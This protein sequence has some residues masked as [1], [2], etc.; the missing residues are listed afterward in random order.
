L[1]NDNVNEADDEPDIDVQEPR[2]PGSKKKRKAE[3]SDEEEKPAI[4]KKPRRAPKLQPVEEE[5]DEEDKHV[6]ATK[7]SSVSSGQ[8]AKL[9]RAEQGAKRKATQN[10]SAESE[11]GM[12]DP[13]YIPTDSD[14]DSGAEDEE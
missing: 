1:A 2:K 7:S 12:S 8:Q 9:S 3:I 4:S 10:D 5:S 6:H 13:I 14:T 11:G